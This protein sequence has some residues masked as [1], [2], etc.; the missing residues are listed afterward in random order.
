M[1]GSAHGSFPLRL[2][3]LRNIY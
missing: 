1:K 2:I 3:H